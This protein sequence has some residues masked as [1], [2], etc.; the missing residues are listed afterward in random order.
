MK[1]SAVALA[2]KPALVL[3][4]PRKRAV[5]P[6]RLHVTLWQTHAWIKEII[7]L[8][9]RPHTREKTQTKPRRFK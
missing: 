1:H 2:A 7:K 4:S 6:W 3:L 5:V 9:K 8:G